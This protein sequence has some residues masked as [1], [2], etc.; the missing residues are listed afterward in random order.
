MTSA[1]ELNLTT[2]ASL[3]SGRNTWHTKAVPGLLPTLVM[4]D[5]PHGVRH[6]GGEGDNLGIGTSTPATCFPTASA[7]ASSWNTALLEEV[8]RALGA[9]ARS[10]GV[11]VLLGP[12]MNIKRSAL[13]GRNFEYFSEDPLLTGHLAAAMVTGI[14]SR[15][16]AA[17]PKHFAV[18]NQETDRMRINAQVDERTLREIYLSAFEH[19]VR[20]A[21]PWALMSAYNRIN[22]DY[23]SEA[24]WLLTDILRQEWGFDGVV[25]S[26]WGAVN[27]RAA[28][29]AAGLD[30][31]MP[32]SNTDDDVLEAVAAGNLRPAALD[33]VAARLGRLASRVDLEPGAP[34]DHQAQHELAHRAASE[35][36]VLLKN[37]TALPLAAERPVLVIG[38]LARSPRIQGG[39]SSRVVPTQVDAPLA[40]LQ[41][42]LAHVQFAE[43][44]TLT[45]DAPSPGLIAE[46]RH[47]ADE[48][49]AVVVFAGLP[50]SAESEGFDRAGIE[51][52]ANQLALLESLRGVEAPVVV[53][54]SA[55]GI[56]DV[57][58]WDGCAQAIVQTSLL[59]QAGG[60][61][62]AD[63]LTG[64]VSPSGR[65]AETIPLALADDPVQLN[66]PGADGQVLYGE[67]RFV[68]YRYFNT[69]RRP[70][71]YPFGFGL[72]YTTFAYTDLRIEPA[73]EN[74]WTARVR[75]RNTGERAGAEVVQL[76]LAGRGED[77]PA[78]ELAA[79][80]KVFLEPEQS[81]EVELSIEPRA[82]SRWDAR[83]HRWRIDAGQVQV[84]VGSSSRDIHLQATIDVRGDGFVP[85]LTPRST[86]GEWLDH[87]RGGDLL[88]HVLEPLRAGAGASAP[89]LLPLL[90]QVP[91]I[92]LVTWPLGL[93]RE[94]IDE[95][96][97]QANTAG[98]SS[99]Q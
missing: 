23:A 20:A 66:F 8:G 43:G 93:T 27:D 4:S 6:Q 13:C 45:P 11:H 65:L 18:N 59:G 82:V 95:M 25:V 69:G 3:T 92:K 5:G 71:A 48:A 9:E 78:H 40:H 63:V 51:L 22:G 99:G 90:L 98:P 50:N 70:V 14:Q 28:S 94:G 96:C 91:L 30:V 80:A 31:E 85:E 42:Q 73:G 17:T 16:V 75:V 15:G 89:E 86:V 55:G 60:R 68:G 57:A 81:R 29:L 36:I 49:G 67:G 21:R 12:G 47:L 38:E 87:P 26:D 58:S 56:V 46:A 62:V 1:P 44:Y 79:F 37:E 33:D 64:A 24:R 88:R 54:L 32:F 35:S 61:A 77:A 19:V 52:P 74:R 53:V 84:Q 72:S 41:A 39:G 97:T 10:L 7:L 2:K 76:Y 34:V 83:Y